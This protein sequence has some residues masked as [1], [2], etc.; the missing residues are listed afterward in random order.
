MLVELKVNIGTNDARRLGIEKTREGEQVDVPEKVAA[1]MLS[2]GWAAEV[3]AAPRKI[4]G[5]PSPDLKAATPG[6]AHESP[7][8]T[9]ASPKPPG[10]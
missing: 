7:P 4:Q 10:K 3:H 5:V 6:P 8:P 1:E 2:K 9:P